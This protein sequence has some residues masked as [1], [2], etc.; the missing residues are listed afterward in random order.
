MPSLLDLLHTLV[1]I[2]YGTDDRVLAPQFNGGPSTFDALQQ[3]DQAPLCLGSCEDETNC[4]RD[5]LAAN[6]RKKE[7]Q[8]TEPH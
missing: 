2:V 4:I 3:A 8:R 1:N 7:L 5:M 6:Q